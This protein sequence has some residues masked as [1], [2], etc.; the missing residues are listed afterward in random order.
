MTRNRRVALGVAVL[1][2]ALVGMRHPTADFR[3]ITHDVRDPSPH[4]MQAAVD[5]G[6]VGVS[7]LYTWTVDRLR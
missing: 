7:V 5:L 3:L 6:L 2:L 1:G 4:Q